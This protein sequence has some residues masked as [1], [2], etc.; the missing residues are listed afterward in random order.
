MFV[1]GGCAREQE[2]LL[3]VRA[4]SWPDDGQCVIDAEEDSTMISGVL[5]V[6]YGTQYLLPLEVANQAVARDPEAT[7]SQTDDAELQIQDALVELEIPQ[8][9]DVIEAL[10]ARDP[11]LVEFSVPL[12][13]I[14]VPGGGSAGVGVPVVSQATSVALRDELGTPGGVRLTMVANV[15]VRARR[16]GNIVGKVGLVPSRS[17]SFPID[18]CNDCLFTCGSCQDGVCPEGFVRGQSALVGFVCGNAQ[19]GIITPVGCE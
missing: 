7:S 10:R 2:S 3:V 9:P 5:D 1:L 14:S 4:P 19:D 6:A 13:T 15:V 16:S 11:A 12:Q 18:L 8:A 17:F